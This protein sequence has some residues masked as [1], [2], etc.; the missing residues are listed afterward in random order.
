VEGAVDGEIECG[1]LRREAARGGR[2]FGERRLGTGPDQA[3][4]LE[5]EVRK[6][7]AKG[8]LSGWRD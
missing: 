2:N 1:R 4:E 6:K 5:E 7:K 8:I 3:E